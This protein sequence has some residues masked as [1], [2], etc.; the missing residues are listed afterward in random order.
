MRED[1][2]AWEVRKEGTKEEERAREGVWRGRVNI[3]KDGRRGEER[4]KERNE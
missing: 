3:N 4:G 1:R 2:N